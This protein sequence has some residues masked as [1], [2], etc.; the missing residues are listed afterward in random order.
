MTATIRIRPSIAMRV[1]RAYAPN[2]PAADNDGCIGL[3][4]G[5]VVHTDLLGRR[6][7][8]EPGPEHLHV[9]IDDEA[10]LCSL[11][12]SPAVEGDVLCVDCLEDERARAE[13]A[14]GNPNDGCRPLGEG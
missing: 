3:L 2:H 14:S 11:C 6:F 12:D 4:E 13:E 9:Y 10:P 5:L 8:I 7:V 1:R